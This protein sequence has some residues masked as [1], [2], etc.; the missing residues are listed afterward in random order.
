METAAAARGYRSI[1]S[2]ATA[3]ERAENFE[4]YWLYTQRND[5]E[6]LEDQKDLT[7][8]RELRARFEAKAVRS[9][10]PL[11]DPERF[12]RN[13]VKIQNDPQTLDRK[14]RLLTFLYKFAR[15]EWV[16]ISAAWDAT[17]P[18]AESIRT[19]QRISRYHLSEEFCHIR[20]FQEMF[21]TFHLDRVEW[22]PLSPWMQRLYAIFPLFPGE[23]LA[24][25]AFVSELLGLTVYL[26]LDRV[27]DDIL[28][29]E[30]E[31][32]EHVRQLLR[33][34]MSDE[35]AHVGQRR[36]FLGPVGLRFAKLIVGPM[37]RTFFRDLPEAKSLFD[38][39]Q[40]VRDGKSFDYSTIPPEILKRSWVPSYCRA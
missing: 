30:P 15:H 7:R 23:L 36:N 1:F 33:E 20:L 22:V 26:H 14:T 18:M 35:L 37:Y 16:G 11:A 38:I 17:A 10:K 40:M 13:C 5:G 12:Y 32:R 6:I 21:R 29:Q 24:P 34:I 9:R 3:Q 27:L 31:A 2:P 28:V 4:D 39:D 19:K 25:P 8:K